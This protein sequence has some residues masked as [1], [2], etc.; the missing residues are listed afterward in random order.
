MNENDNQEVLLAQIILMTSIK[1]LVI[2]VAEGFK[3][4]FALLYIVKF[5]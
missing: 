2:F 1:L 5:R 4:D 3:L